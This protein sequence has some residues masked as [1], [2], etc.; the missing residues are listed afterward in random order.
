MAQ[1]FDEDGQFVNDDDSYYD[2][3]HYD[4]SRDAWNDDSAD[5]FEDDELPQHRRESNSG[6]DSGKG[7]C[8][9]WM[10]LV[11]VSLDL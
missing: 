6:Q 5:M 7:N 11:L 3:G 2:D 8:L 10:F 1:N 9:N 4:K